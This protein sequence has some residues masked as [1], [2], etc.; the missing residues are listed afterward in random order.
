MLLF[1]L[2]KTQ[3]DLVPGGGSY[4]YILL[5]LHGKFHYENWKFKS[6]KNKKEHHHFIIIPSH[7]KVVEGI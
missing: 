3:T 7:N 4:D 1:E 2:E 5:S 6:W